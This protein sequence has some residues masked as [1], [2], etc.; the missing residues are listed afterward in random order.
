MVLLCE[1]VKYFIYSIY[2]YTLIQKLKK[3][4]KTEIVQ[5]RILADIL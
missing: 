5:K 2:I 4:S 3:N 1:V